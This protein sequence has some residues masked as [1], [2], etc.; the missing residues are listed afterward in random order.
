[1]TLAYCAW[2]PSLSALPMSSLVPSTS[3][4]S[5]RTATLRRA[6][7]TLAPPGETFGIQARRL[8]RLSA[9][10]FEP[11]DQ[12]QRKMAAA[13]HGR[14][15]SGWCQSK[16]AATRARQQ[17]TQQRLLGDFPQRIKDSKAL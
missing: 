17:R 4:V 8:W 13:E 15:V 1:M 3:A 11:L 2:P 12:R 7:R 5:A 6:T 9:L 10:Q 16:P 14:H